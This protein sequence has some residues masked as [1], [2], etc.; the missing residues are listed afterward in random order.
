M[1]SLL[2]ESPGAASRGSSR[3]CLLLHCCCCCCPLCCC[4]P[5]PATPRDLWCR[6]GT[7]C[8]R[9]SWQA[10]RA[11]E[12]AGRDRLLGCSQEDSPTCELPTEV[13]TCCHTTA[14]AP[15]AMSSSRKAAAASGGSRPN[16]CGGGWSVAATAAAA[17][18]SRE[19]PGVSGGGAATPAWHTSA[20]PAASLT[21]FQLTVD[22]C[23]VPQWDVLRGRD[24]EHLCV[25]FGVVRCRVLGVDT[26]R[27]SKLSRPLTPRTPTH[28]TPRHA[29]GC[30][31]TTPG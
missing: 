26:P 19:P 3:T 16:M 28:A 22:G 25:L 9:A 31:C 15:A 11:R 20:S 7:A 2:P 29:P 30:A 10:Q 14:P 8:K 23:V 4:R 18:V 27:G 6:C 21:A 5:H 12:A 1:H 17:A 13:D 24:N